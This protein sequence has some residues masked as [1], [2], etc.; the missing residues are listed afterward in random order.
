MTK[1][2]FQIGARIGRFRLVAPI[3]E[4]AMGRVWRADGPTEPVAIKEL[5]LN[6]PGMV[7][8]FE[9]EALALLKL[10]HPNV[11]RAIDY[12]HADDGTPFMAMELLEGESLED[13]LLR[14][15]R[16]EIDDAVRIVYDAALGLGAAHAIGLVHRDVKP[17]NLF[18]TEEGEVKV[19]DFGIAFWTAADGRAAPSRLTAPG[20]VLGTPSYM[21]PE[22]AKGARDEDVTTDVWGLGAVLYHA[23]CGREPFGAD[24][25]YLAE[26][27]RILTQPPDPLPDRVPLNIASAIMKALS[28]P[29]AQRFASMTELAQA[30]RADA[31]MPPPRTS[32]VD[33]M[34]SLSEEVRLVS[35]VLVEGLAAEHNRAFVESVKRHGGIGSPMLGERAVA[36]FGG[37]EW[38][39]DEAER[40]VKVALDVKAYTTRIAIGTG[41]AI[42]RIDARGAVTGQAISAAQQALSADEPTVDTIRPGARETPSCTVVVCAETA[43]RVQGGFSLVGSRVVGVLPGGRALRPREVGGREIPFVGRDAA[44]DELIGVV[45]EVDESGKSAAVVIVGPPGIGKSRLRFELLRWVAEEELPARQ[46]EARGELSRGRSSLDVLRELL[47]SHAALSDGTST[48]EARARIEALVASAGL[49][50]P[51]FIG[52]LLGVPFPANPHLEAARADPRL[53]HDRIH[54]AMI[55]L[56]AGWT[57]RGLVLVSIEDA[58]WADEASLAFLDT[59]LVELRDRPFVLVV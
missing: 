32:S 24:G 29:R 22:Q 41:K 31:P 59:L 39:G 26:L 47:R 4:G 1:S 17:G 18:V 30:L 34:G 25:N 6:D 38:L 33:V 28:K 5:N 21:A 19:L 36:V 49:D 48:E 55:D 54:K 43:R 50:A 57:E 40:A 23:I 16:L 56:F 10:R 20:I 35:A 37:D 12:G 9:R 52:E 51:D 44:L 27:T 46:L 42:R 15:G 3:D 2:C 58:Q 8:R 14:L 45:S 53:M 13:R 11:V 7:E